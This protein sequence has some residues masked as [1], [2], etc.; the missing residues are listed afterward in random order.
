[1]TG[2]SI[3][4][5]LRRYGLITL[6]CT[7]YA[8]TFNC[9]FQA[10]HL[11]IGGFTG[12][13]QVLNRFIPALPV[14]T[15]VFVMNLP[16]LIAGGKKVGW[17]LLFSTLF[18]TFMS[19]VLIDSV[20]LLYTFSPREPL[21]AALYGGVL[22]GVSLGIMLKQ[23]ATTG[24]TELLARLLKFR[25]RGL[26]IGRLCLMIDAIVI[27]LYALAFRSLDN[28][29][30]GIVTMY[31]SSIAMDT[32]VYGSV[33]GKMAFIISDKSEAITQKLMDMDLGATVLSGKGA[34]TGL[35]KNVLLCAT[36]SSRLATIKTAVT[37]IDPEKA[38][39]IVCDAR[40]VFGEGFGEYSEDSL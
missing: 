14:G 1:M 10:N 29:L 30:Y 11:A 31:V 19:N 28:A 6:S 4:S 17:K 39:I 26:S 21:L 24:G 12:I 36:K 13:A 22:L 32:V 8:L 23:G 27:S 15:T 7:L 40:E 25:F 34:F 37:S 2:K 33:S 35:P 5:I 3:L 20:A 9:F 16:L 38:F 18:A